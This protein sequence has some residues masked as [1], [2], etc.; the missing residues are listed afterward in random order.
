MFLIILLFLKYFFL[1]ICKIGLFIELK[2][3]VFMDFEFFLDNE[4]IVDELLL[5]V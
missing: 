4:F 5:F 2:D 3:D 1:V